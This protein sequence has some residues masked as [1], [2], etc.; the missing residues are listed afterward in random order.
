MNARVA[1]IVLTHNQWELTRA[2]L[3][4]VLPGADARIRVLVVDNASTDGTPVRARELFPQVEVIGNKTNLGYAR[5]NNVGLQ[6]ALDENMDYAMILN[7]DVTVAPNCLD[8]L[9]AAADENPDAALLGPMVYHAQERNVI[10]SAGGVLPNDWH[11]R[12]RGANQADEQQFT[13]TT[14]VDWLT[15]CAVLARVSAVRKFGLLDDGFFMY[16]EDVDWGVRARQAGYRV[17]F[18]PKARVWHSGVQRDYAPPPYVTYYSARNELQLMHKHHAGMSPLLG[19]W[20]RNLR[21]VASWSVL[22]RWRNQRAQRDALA[23][24]LR[25]AALHRTGRGEVS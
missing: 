14:N 23:R 9:V 3:E 2:C 12:H 8:A 17:L 13:Q 15:G 18:V 4:T 6:Y 20:A 24:A 25:D 1:V 19:A 5:G 21:T 7:N 11:S 16:G 10:Q 22:P